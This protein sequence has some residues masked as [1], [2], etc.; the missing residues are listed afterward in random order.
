[1]VNFSANSQK[2][3]DYDNKKMQ[4]KMQRGKMTNEQKTVHIRCNVSFNCQCNKQ[5]LVN[6]CLRCKFNQGHK[7]PGADE[8]NYQP[9]ISSSQPLTIDGRIRKMTK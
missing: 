1:M 2:W 7:H 4:E 8:N 6:K 9:V 5:G 3:K